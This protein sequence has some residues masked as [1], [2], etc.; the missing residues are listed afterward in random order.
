MLAGL[1][2]NKWYELALSL[3][4]NLGPWPWP[5]IKVKPFDASK[6]QESLE[7][8][9]SP[10]IQGRSRILPIDLPPAT[11]PLATAELLEV[12]RLTQGKPVV[13]Y[14]SVSRGMCCRWPS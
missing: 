6:Q 1:R 14:H 4:H 9:F 11:K 12:E 8:L 7:L 10:R 2:N 13:A 5:G 3:E